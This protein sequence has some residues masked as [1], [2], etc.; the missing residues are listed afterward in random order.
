[1]EQWKK[2]KDYENY[3]VSN[4]GNVKNDIT[5][6]KIYLNDKGGNYLTVNLS[7]NGKIKRFYVHRLVAQSFIENKDNKLEVNHKDGNKHNN[8]YTNL[9]WVTRSENMVHALKNNLIDTSKISKAHTGKIKYN[10]KVYSYNLKTK[11]IKIHNNIHD[12][13]NE[14][15]RVE[16]YRSIKH[17]TTHKGFI[18]SKNNDFSEFANL[19]TLEERRIKIN[20]TKP[21]SK[22]RF[23][24]KLKKQGLNISDYD[25]QF[26]NKNS[27]G[28]KQ[29]LFFKKNLSKSF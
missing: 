2:I 26:V 18:F 13:F 20:E 5:N 19:L 22:Y 16:V 29:Y 15:D 23:K 24:L 10:Y 1:M 14:F 25:M 28:I 6:K 27:R 9:E 4:F 3:S 11:E 17:K 21:I 12:L 8:Y 7:K